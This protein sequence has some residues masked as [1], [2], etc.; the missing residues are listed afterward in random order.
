MTSL[1]KMPSDPDTQTLAIRDHSRRRNAMSMSR[2]SS[3]RAISSQRPALT[4]KTDSPVLSSERKIGGGGGITKQRSTD[5]K[6]PTSLRTPLAHPL[7]HHVSATH[8]PVHESIWRLQERLREMGP[9]YLYS[10]KIPFDI[11]VTARPL[12]SL[13]PTSS[14]AGT[15]ADLSPSTPNCSPASVN[16]Y[17]RIRPAS[18][19]PAKLI[20]RNFRLAEARATIPE[21]RQLPPRSSDAG[22]TPSVPT[23]CLPGAGFASQKTLYE[24]GVSSPVALSARSAHPAALRSPFTYRTAPLSAVGGRDGQRAVTGGFSAVA[25]S[26]FPEDPLIGFER[27]K[28][29]TS[30][31]VAKMNTDIVPPRE[32]F[33]FT[34]ASS[35]G[36]PMHLEY[37]RAYLP[38]LASLML[39]GHVSE[40]DDIEICLPCPDAWADTVSHV[41]TGLPK[42]NDKIR[43][44]SQHLGGRL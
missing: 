27:R 8:S 1:S 39:S 18:G 25:K 13:T 40:K 24:L 3:P 5:G 42:M 4:V 15:A 7:S 10:N 17:A 30:L 6:T 19:S 38:I 28:S 9:A 12:S 26:P 22:P 32:G 34:E 41:Y 14:T 35:T 23:P 16:I 43:A 21:A 2:R 20:R 11:Y 33:S 31:H 37:A 44:N 36:V 29:L